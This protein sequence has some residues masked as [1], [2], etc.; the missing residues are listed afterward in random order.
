MAEIRG[1]TRGRLAYNSALFEVATIR[2]ILADYGAVAGRW[3]RKTRRHGL[4][5]LRLRGSQSESYNDPRLEHTQD[6]MDRKT[7]SNHNWS[8]SGKRF[9]ANGRLV[10]RTISLNWAEPLS[11]LRRL[12]AQ[13][14][15]AFKLSIPLVSLVQAPTIT[16]LA[17]VIH[18]AD[19]SN[20]WQLPGDNSGGR[21]SSPSLL[22]SRRIGKPANVPQLGAALESGSAGLW[23]AAARIRR[24][25][26]SS[27]KN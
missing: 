7:A 19:S 2:Q 9:S 10:S 27:D 1:K 25:T 20:A 15:E 8:G 14:E 6:Y 22:H 13:I 3:C 12:F 11:L 24:Q 23:V 16:K 5:S 18:A 21:C 17:K 4:V 26:G